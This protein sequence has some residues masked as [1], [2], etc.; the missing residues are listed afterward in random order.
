M[1]VRAVVGILC[2]SDPVRLTMCTG[3]WHDFS[4]SQGAMCPGI[5]VR[6]QFCNGAPQLSHK[7]PTVLVGVFC[8]S[9]FLRGSPCIPLLLVRSP[10]TRDNE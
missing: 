3:V 1:H 7:Q 4:Q 5:G 8:V 2:G 9:G 10:E 6:Y